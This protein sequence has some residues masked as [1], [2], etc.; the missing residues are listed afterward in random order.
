MTFRRLLPTAMLG[1]LLE[2]GAMAGDDGSAT[3]PWT[4]TWAAA[5]QPFMPG[6]LETY[7]HE[8][9]RLIVHTSIAGSGVRVSLSNAFGDVPLTVSDVHIALRTAGADVE[10]GSDRAVRF[11]GEV[12]ATIGAHSQL[13]SDAVALQVPALTDLAVSFFLPQKI[14]ATTSHLLALQTSYVAQGNNAAAAQFPVLK[15][16][17]TW[18]FLT[19]VDVRTPSPASAIAILGS[20]T[21][22]GDGSTQDKNRRWPDVLAERLHTAGGAKARLGVLNLGIIGNRLLKDSP[23]ESPFGSGLGQAAL[24][25]FEQDVL[26]RAGVRILVVCMGINDITFPGTFTSPDEALSPEVLIEG[27]RQLTARA[28]SHGIRVI[29][30]TIPP[31]EN[32]VYSDKTLIVYT[33]AKELVRQEINS[34]IRTTKDF[35][36]M[37]DFDAVVRDPARPSRLLPRFDSG[38]H[39][40]TNDAGYAAIADSVSLNLFNI[41]LLPAHRANLHGPELSLP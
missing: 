32:A 18:P 11:R 17:E 33:P 1:I 30:T 5:P 6:N 13:L 19:G 31:F 29:G 40:H 38:D 24:T 36:A 7:E 35:D 23:K 16:I 20:S 9:L 4:G 2:V 39:L 21:T 12:T 26:A 14:D 34:W 22:D 15:T 8:T 10:P 41:P 28:H 27:Y 37:V 25:R 3:A